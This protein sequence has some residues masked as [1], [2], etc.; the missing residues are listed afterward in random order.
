MLH[1]LRR[2]TIPLALALLLILTAC[3]GGQAKAPTATPAPTE[4]PTRTPR[5]TREPEPTAE[6]TAK[7]TNVVLTDNS[8]GNGNGNDNSNGNGSELKPVDIGSLKTY[9]HKSG[10]FQIDIPNNWDL[11]DNSKS[12]E[13]ILI[14]TDPS[15]NGA[16]IVDIFEDSKTYSEADLTDTLKKYLE[17]SFSDKPDFFL[18]DPTPQKDGS[19][20]IVW[21]YTATADNNVKAPLLGNTFIEQRGNKI[22]LLSTLVPQDQFDSLIDKTNE[23]INTYKIDEKASIK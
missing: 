7:P 23:I 8:N 17:N 9:A 1:A 13:L 19:I 5:P 21:T 3:G 12:D 14:W 10:V 4:A 18:E 15:R 22:S 20:L 11:Q 2:L 6:P 16:V